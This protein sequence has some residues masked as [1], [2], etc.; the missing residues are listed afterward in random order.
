MLVPETLARE[1][2]PTVRTPVEVEMVKSAEVVAVPPAWPKRSWPFTHEVELGSDWTVRPVEVTY[3]LPP[4]SKMFWDWIYPEAVMFVE[5]TLV[6][7][8]FA[9]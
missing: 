5:D 4:R 6:T 9:A 3:L 1:E 2:E 7:Y 8:P